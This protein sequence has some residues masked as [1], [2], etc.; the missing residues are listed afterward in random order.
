MQHESDTAFQVRQ[1]RCVDRFTSINKMQSNAT[2]IYN[3]IIVVFDC[4]LLILVV[5]QPSQN[6]GYAL[7]FDKFYSFPEL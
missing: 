7:Y 3:Y 1:P 6:K 5:I 4:I 2:I